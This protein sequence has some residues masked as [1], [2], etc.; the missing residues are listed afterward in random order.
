LRLVDHTLKSPF[1]DFDTILSLGNL[2]LEQ[3]KFDEA[4]SY[5]KVAIELNPKSAEAWHSCGVALANQGK[6]ITSINFFESALSL[7]PDLPSPY[8]NL[9]I[10]YSKLSKNHE[11][12]AAFKKAL[13][14]K[15]DCDD[16]YWSIVNSLS[17]L[18][19]IQNYK[20]LDESVKQYLI[21]CREKSPIR[22]SLAFFSNC[23]V[24]GS[25]DEQAIAKLEELESFLYQNVEVISNLDI[26]ALYASLG[27]TLPNL[28]DDLAKN[29]QILRL[30][31]ELYMRKI[32]ISVSSNPEY[33]KQRSLP[34]RQLRH[35]THT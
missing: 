16:A 20:F 18:Q 21:H 4:Y 22:T 19:D 31:G 10:V 8:Y 3:R 23:L 15:P 12:R 25:T 33:D 13:E 9:G 34:Q 28:R 11:S 35:P 2:H 5:Y 30:I 7:D 29:S 27:F 32:L 26:S 17:H 1:E 14:L 24:Q 6:L